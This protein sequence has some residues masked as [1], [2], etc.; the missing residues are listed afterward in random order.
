[1]GRYRLHDPGSEKQQ[2]AQH[3]RTGDRRNSHTDD[4]SAAH[5]LPWADSHKSA[6]TSGLH[7]G[8]AAQNAASDIDAMNRWALF[9]LTSY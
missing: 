5:L 1:M 7:V 2:R 3:N 9:A 6:G 4:G 8:V